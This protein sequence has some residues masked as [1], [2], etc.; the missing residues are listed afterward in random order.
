MKHKIS[1]DLVSIKT[2]IRMAIKAVGG[3]ALVGSVYLAY[4]LSTT[5]FA[6]IP[7]IGALTAFFTVL[8]V[9]GAVLVLIY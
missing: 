1:T 8:L 9:I 3:V 5:S 6:S 2:V 4:S 7:L